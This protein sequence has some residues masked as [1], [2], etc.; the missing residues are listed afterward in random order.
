MPHG[1]FYVSPVAAFA[2]QSEAR[3]IAGKKTPVEQSCTTGKGAAA[4]QRQGMRRLLFHRGFF[5][6]VVFKSL[7]FLA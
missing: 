7:N 1:F 5:A 2:A 4:R 6:E 3:I